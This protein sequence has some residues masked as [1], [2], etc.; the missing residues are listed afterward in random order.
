[1]APTFFP[2]RFGSTS[3]I[4]T[5]R[6]PWSA[7]MSESAI[8][9]PRL[10]A[11]NRAMLRWPEVRRSFWRWGASGS[12]DRAALGDEPGDVVADAALAELAEAGEI[13]PDLRG[14]DVGVVG[15]LLR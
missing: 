1:M 12:Q 7:K 4:A 14:V 5:T 9:C 2:I 8:A 10:P 6:N 3:K 11:P 15:Q 13:S